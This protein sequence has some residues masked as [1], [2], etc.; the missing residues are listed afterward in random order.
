MTRPFRFAAVSAP[1]T[2]F[3]QLVQEAKAAEGSG[4]DLLVLPDFPAT[5]SPIAALA[6]LAAHTSTLRFSP[7]VV[8]AGL[9][10][11]DL[12]VREFLTADQISGGRVE[13]G[14][15]AGVGPGGP[16]KPLT[17]LRN[18]VD[19]IRASLDDAANPPGW[20]SIPLILI[21]GSGD[22]LLRFAGERGDAVGIA[23]PFPPPSSLP[24]GRIPLLS[25]G[26]ADER[27][28]AIRAGAGDR[29]DQIDLNVGAEVHITTDRQAAAEEAHEAHSYLSV[30]EILTSPKFLAG[31]TEEIAEQLRGHR[32]RFGL[33]YF[34]TI[35]ISAA[36]FAPVIDAL[37]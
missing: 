32:E 34:A 13:I 31:T 20:V 28:A 7:L 2:P 22:N 12:L 6:A 23:G 36:E 21:A 33:N 35:G 5:I 18:A 29:F 37:R 25:P 3:A 19:T 26:A 16:P 15:G 14:L 24:P 4:F 9:W 10:R 27:I 17:H 8:N 11:P 30:D 1:S